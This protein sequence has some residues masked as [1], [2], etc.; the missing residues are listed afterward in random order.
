MFV[1][2]SWKLVTP[3][4]GSREDSGKTGPNL[5]TRR[6]SVRRGP[7]GRDRLARA[8]QPGLRVLELGQ[9][10]QRVRPAPNPVERRDPLGLNHCVA[11]ALAQPVL[12]QLE[13]HAQQLAEQPGQRRGLLAAALERLAQLVQR[14]QRVATG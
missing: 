7:S 10:G 14:G 13:L 11:E 9:R 3:R 4:R 5:V 12:A 8:A 6:T 1:N 2:R